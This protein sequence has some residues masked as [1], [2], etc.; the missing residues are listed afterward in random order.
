MQ[1]ALLASFEAPAL[2]DAVRQNDSRLHAPPCLPRQVLAERSV[3][4]TLPGRLQTPRA[5]GWFAHQITP[6]S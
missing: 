3:P 4:R 2:P 5:A 6:S 1:N